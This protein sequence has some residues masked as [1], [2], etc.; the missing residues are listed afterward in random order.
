MT[1]EE[2]A[3]NERKNDIVRQCLHNPVR[4]GVRGFQCSL[5]G[6][7]FGV[8]MFAR[9]VRPMPIDWDDDS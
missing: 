9:K 6:C 8:L 1:D 5:C 3:E 4:V 2:D 7:R